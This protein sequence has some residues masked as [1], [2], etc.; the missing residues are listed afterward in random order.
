MM[1][2]GLDILVRS[3]Q[4][5]DINFLLASTL[6]GLY[7]GSRFWGEVDQVAFFNNYEPYL[8]QLMLRR[9]I[10]VACLSDDQDVILGFSIFKDE[11]LDWVFIKKSYRKLGIGKLLVPDTIT[12]VSHITDSGNSIRKTKGW[13]FNP[14]SV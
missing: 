2:N 3:P 1:I 11:T 8:K 5:G 12:T 4:P 9:D 10:K 13:K 14:F 7:Y 6:K